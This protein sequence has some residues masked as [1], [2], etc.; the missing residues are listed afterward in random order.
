MQ[1]IGKWPKANEI[2]Q[3]KQKYKRE[4][5]RKREYLLKRCTKS[6][7]NETF[8]SKPIVNVK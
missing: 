6:G 4:R 3:H 2:L 5:E 7:Q 1:Q 8:N